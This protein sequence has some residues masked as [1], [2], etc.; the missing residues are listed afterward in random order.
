MDSNR[1]RSGDQDSGDQV[2][3]NATFPIAFVGPAAA[4]AGALNAGLLQAAAWSWM[5]F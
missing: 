3:R 1:N 2:A 4:E 5:I